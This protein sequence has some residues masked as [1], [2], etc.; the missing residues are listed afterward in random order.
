MTSSLVIGAL[1]LSAVVL[2]LATAVLG[3]LNQGRIS[4]AAKITKAT[5]SD[6]QQISV[7][8]DGRL[9]TLLERQAQLLSSMH[10]A[11][12]PIPP[13]PPEPEIPGLPQK[14]LRRDETP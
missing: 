1:A 9:S 2:G 3:L 5:A 14:T 8:V 10:E 11:G 7:Q 12:V 4:R 13:R 6:V